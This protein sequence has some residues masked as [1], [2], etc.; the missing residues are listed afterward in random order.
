MPSPAIRARASNGGNGGTPN[1]ATGLRTSW[2]VYRGAGTVT[3]DPPQVETWEDHRDGANSP[4][5]A[6]FTTPP[7]PPGGKWDVHATFSTP[8]TY[9]L[10]CLTSD[11]ALLVSQDVTVVVE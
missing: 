7:T 8:G 10:R 1:A 3:F 11:G 5:A 2:F 4:W 6:G 9:V